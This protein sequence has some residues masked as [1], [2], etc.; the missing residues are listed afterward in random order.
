MTYRTTPLTSAGFRPAELLMGRRFRTTLPSLE[1][2]LKPNWT[3]QEKVRQADTA[4]TLKQ[5]FYYNHS[6]MSWRV[7]TTGME[8]E[9]LDDTIYI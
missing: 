1:E 8:S 5:A 2:N 3:D 6:V 7:M 4:A 9:T